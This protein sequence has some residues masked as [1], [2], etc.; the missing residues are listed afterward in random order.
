MTDLIAVGYCLDEIKEQTALPSIRQIDYPGDEQTEGCCQCSD[1]FV[2]G[3]GGWASF[4][5]F[6]GHLLP[7]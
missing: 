7:K 4:G 1:G 3:F 6:R 5:I 2:H